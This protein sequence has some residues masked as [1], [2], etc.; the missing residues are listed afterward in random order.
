MSDKPKSRGKDII[1]ATDE[2]RRVVG[3]LWLP[4]PPDWR[5]PRENGKKT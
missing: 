2:S 1:L 4:L 5:R 3:F